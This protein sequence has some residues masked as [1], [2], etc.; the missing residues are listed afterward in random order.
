MS[1]HP[2]TATRTSLALLA[3]LALLSALLPDGT[4]PAH[5]QESASAEVKLRIIRSEN[6]QIVDLDDWDIGSFTANDTLTDR[7]SPWDEACVFSSTSGYRLDLQ[8]ANGPGPLT[9]RSTSGAGMAY[10]ILISSRAAKNGQFETRGFQSTPLVLD[11]RRGSRSV[12]CVGGPGGN[13]NISFAALVRP[14]AFNAAPPGAYQDTVT[15]IVSA[16]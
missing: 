4:R 1:T 7:Q 8:S 10:E 13:T 2:R 9:L 14:A 16:E 11:A 6:V 5:A 12:Q 15:L 3:S